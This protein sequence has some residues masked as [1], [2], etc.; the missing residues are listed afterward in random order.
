MAAQL[1]LAM[2]AD[3]TE[4][5]LTGDLYTARGLL[6]L[7]AARFPNW[8]AEFTDIV[9]TI[10]ATFTQRSLPVP[11]PPKVRMVDPSAMNEVKPGDSQ[12][13]SSAL[14]RVEAMKNSQARDKAYQELAVKAGLK[15]D[16][17]L[18]ESIMSKIES[19]DIHREATVMVYRPLAR[20]A[21][22]E[23][24]WSYAQELALNVLD[25]L[26]RTLLFD[27]I[28]QAMSQAHQDRSLVMDVYRLA[29]AR[30]EREDATPSVAKAFLMLAKSLWPIDPE[31][32]VS[33]V[34][35]AVWMLNKVAKND[36]TLAEATA[37]EA[38]N[39]LVSVP[40]R[41]QN[42]DDVL[43]L[44]EVLANAFKDLAKRNA[45]K[46]LMVADGLTH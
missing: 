22:A 31:A 35:S 37:W 16:L 3:K 17:S 38:A 46:G 34:D 41:C 10:E 45:D 44:P 11:G 36:E 6:S 1:R 12:E 27:Y 4:H 40:N 14:P 21:V 19:E 30:L 28:A 24:N 5:D 9:S 8:Q 15:T 26:G 39:G 2:R 32:S 23:A 29:T 20:K 13:I 33:A 43:V 7:A 18:A 25:P 42:F